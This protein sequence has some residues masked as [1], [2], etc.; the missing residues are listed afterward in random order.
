MARIRN[1]DHWDASLG[2]WMLAWIAF[3]GSTPL[4]VRVLQHALATKEGKTEFSDDFLVDAEEMISVCGGLISVDQGETVRLIDRTF[5]HYFTT[6]QRYSHFKEVAGIGY[7][8]LRYLDLN[9]FDEPCPDLE[10]LRQRLAK[11]V[12]SPYAARHWARHIQG[13]EEKQMLN[14][15]LR[16]F[17]SRGKRE[18]ISQFQEYVEGGSFRKF[19]GKSLLHIVAE[20]GLATICHSLLSGNLVEGK[21]SYG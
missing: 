17:G 11:Y 16:V 3:S 12:L 8:C 15:V 14:T 13:D 10:S 18:S 6:N 7:V 20:N 21:D 5:Y 9:E 4:T 1:Q 19:T 2:E